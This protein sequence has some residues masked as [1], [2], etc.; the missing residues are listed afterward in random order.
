MSIPRW[1]HL[2]IIRLYSGRS[3]RGSD[4]WDEGEEYKAPRSDD[5]SL[6]LASPGY[7]QFETPTQ[8][9][10]ETTREEDSPLETED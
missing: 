7:R 5:P 9:S 1:A 10:P 4:C 2:G 8:D 6:R 3:P